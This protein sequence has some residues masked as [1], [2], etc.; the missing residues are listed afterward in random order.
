MTNAIEVTKREM[1]TDL[2]RV[3]GMVGTTHL[4]KTFEA[5]LEAHLEALRQ[6][7]SAKAARIGELYS[8]VRQ[9]Q[10]LHAEL[11]AKFEEQQEELNNAQMLSRS[12]ARQLAGTKE[13][14][15]LMTVLGALM[16]AQRIMTDWLVPDGVRAR[17]TVKALLPVLDNEN[18]ALA[19]REFEKTKTGE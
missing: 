5:S 9:W 10:D 12:Y 19:I 14:P 7:D 13:S 11:Q 17:D 8:T 18:L 2:K 6:E 1:Y 3:G 4:F 15:A 16:D